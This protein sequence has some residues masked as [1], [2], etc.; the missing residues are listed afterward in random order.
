MALICAITGAADGIGRALTLAWA[1]QGATIYGI[2]C[3]A[4]RLAAVA[5][6]AQRL[7]GLVRPFEVDLASAAERARLLCELAALP[8]AQIWVHN[9]G[10][11]A[12]GRFAALSWAEQAAVLELNLHAPLELTAAL[13]GQRLLAQ[14][15]SL[16]LLASLACYTGYPG[17]SV[18]A[19][20]KSGLAAYARGV[21]AAYLDLHVLTVFPGPVRTA[22]ARRYSP[23]NRREARRMP[24]ERLAQLVLAAVA[25]RR[26]RLIPGWGSWLLA[27]LGQIAPGLSARLMGRLM[28]DRT[29]D[30]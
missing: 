16:V 26:T 28:L 7:G 21:R 11:S 17:A 1:G 3:D 27:G 18:Y 15:G 14:D 30:S 10:I 20:T 25:R 24:P 5:D 23:D 22:H 2:D 9:A 6:E 4:A 8:P 12:A 19:A 13:L 29:A